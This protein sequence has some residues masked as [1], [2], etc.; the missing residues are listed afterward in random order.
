MNTT[1]W[2]APVSCWSSSRCRTR[3]ARTSEGVSE[4]P[5][6]RGRVTVH[7][8]RLITSSSDGS[9]TG[10]RYGSP[11]RGGTDTGV[12]SGTVP[13]PWNRSC[14]PPH[15]PGG[16]PLLLDRIYQ[17]PLVENTQRVEDGRLVRPY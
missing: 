12:G 7:P 5:S 9:T 15:E 14:L 3:A 16:R 4:K 13:E 6:A 17:A 11:Y 10:S 2:F 1:E 8:V